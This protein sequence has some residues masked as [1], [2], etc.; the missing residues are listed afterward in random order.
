MRPIF[1]L[2]VLL[3]AVAS[4]S[5]D[6][7]TTVPETPTSKSVRFRIFQAQDYSAPR[8]DGVQAELRISLARENKRTGATTVA[9]DTTFTMR[10]LRNFPATTTPLELT[11]TVS[12][13]FESR[14]VLRVSRSIRYLN[15]DNSTSM[16]GR[17][18][19]VP[20][21]TREARFDISL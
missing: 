2:A 11:R 10:S 3:L 18:E 15:P 4:C 8:F 16:N 14:E 19:T 5:K 7:E 13:I 21:G 17:G 1:F 20:E 6:N 9:W 12:N